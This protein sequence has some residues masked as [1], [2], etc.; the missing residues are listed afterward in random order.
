[1]SPADGI[2]LSAPDPAWPGHY[3]AEAADLL[4]VLPA[5]PGLRL[6]HFGSTAVPDLRAK[7]VIDILVIHPQPERWPQLIAAVESLGYVCWR[8]NPRKDRLF[9]VKGMPPYGVRRTHHVHVRVPKDAEKELAFRDLLRGAPAVARRY[10]ALKDDLAARYPLD[11]EAYTEA[12]T[13]FIEAALAECL[14][15]PARAFPSSG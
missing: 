8:D 4:G 2:A 13:T 5:V 1:V 10:E 11:R 7:P 3:A 6:E 15:R 12:K 9:F 14:R